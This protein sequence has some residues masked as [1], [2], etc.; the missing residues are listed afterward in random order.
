MLAYTKMYVHCSALYSV[1]LI[2]TLTRS[3]PERTVILSYL[4]KQ[5]RQCIQY[6]LYTFNQQKYWLLLILKIYFPIAKL[7]LLCSGKMLL[8]NLLVTQSSL[9]N[10]LIQPNH[11]YPCSEFRKVFYEMFSLILMRRLLDQLC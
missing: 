2:S 6:R 7:C 1:K 4:N 5:T 10:K 8:F 11:S 3:T 9:G